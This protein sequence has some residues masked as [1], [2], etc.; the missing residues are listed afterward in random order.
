[1]GEV[2]N[3]S[4]GSRET[5]KEVFSPLLKF[6]GSSLGL[7]EKEYIKFA[8]RGISNQVDPRNVDLNQPYAATFTHPVGSLS[9]VIDN[10]ILRYADPMPRFTSTV[11][12]FQKGIDEVDDLT[13]LVH[14]FSH[15]VMPDVFRA[16][17][18]QEFDD[19]SVAIKNQIIQRRKMLEDPV[20]NQ[21]DLDILDLMNFRNW[22]NIYTFKYTSKPNVNFVDDVQESFADLFSY[23]G[24][25]KVTDP[26]FKSKHDNI[27]IQI[28]KTLKALFDKVFR[29]VSKMLNLCL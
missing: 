6:L 11:Q 15:T 5:T 14:E 19:L 8:I 7:D 3:I 2:L 29:K 9:Q 21:S 23:W 27:F 18:Q 12:L 17:P 1:M 4:K 10:T 13:T 16:L 28:A 26:N 24:L 25:Q 22:D 20:T